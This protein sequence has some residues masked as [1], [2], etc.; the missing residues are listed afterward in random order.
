MLLKKAGIIFLLGG[1]FFFSSVNVAEAYI[2]EGWKF[3]NKVTTYK[4]G[5]RLTTSGSIIRNGWEAGDAA[6]YNASSFN[7]LENSMSVNVLNSWVESSSSYYGR[8]T[9]Y[10]DSSTKIVSRIAGDINAGNTNITTANVAKST[11]VHELGHAIGIAHNSGTSI[12][13]SSRN[14]AT[15]HVPQTDDKNGVNAIY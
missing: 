12:M 14:R 11:A 3:T 10:F 9:T 4:W 6:W 13:N 1:I 15:M 2:K 8:M 5:D 7:F